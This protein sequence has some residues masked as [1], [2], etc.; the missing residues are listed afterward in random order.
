MLVT[1]AAHQAGNLSEGLRGLGATPVEVPV[2][3]VRPPTSLDALDRALRE[4]DSYDWLVLTSTNTVAA[5]E[6]RALSLGIRLSGSNS[7]K[8]AAIGAG[9]AAAAR[10][11]GLVIT[12]VPVSY[13]AESLIEGLSTQVLG[14]RILLARAEVARDVIPD[15]LQAL[16]AE[17]DVVDAYRNALPDEAPGQL[18]RGLTEG[19]D[20][21]TFTSSSSATHL[22]QASRLAGLAWPFAGVPAVSIGPITSRTLR[23]LGWVP[24]VEANPSDIPG[25]IS[26][27]VHL[28]RPQVSLSR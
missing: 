12:L 19:I 15:A 2:I 1:R 18:R 11:A 7:M 8:I 6:E 28:F 17:V 24:A 26:A 21:V 10:R 14:K 3:E 5:L 27:V 20:A 4:L 25:L 23:D 22:S 13:V 9:T 16:G